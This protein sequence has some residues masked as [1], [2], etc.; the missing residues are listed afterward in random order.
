M[1]SG[2][3]KFKEGQRWRSRLIGDSFTVQ[4]VREGEK[5]L[6]VIWDSNTNYIADVWS[7]DV[8]PLQLERVD[9]RR[10]AVKP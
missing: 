7:H 3:K 5:R 6:R 10:G 9:A 1:R 8:R 2:L 4:D